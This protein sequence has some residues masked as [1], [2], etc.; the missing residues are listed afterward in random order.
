MYFSAQ[1]DLKRREITEGL[2]RVNAH[3]LGMT[4]VRGG[5]LVHY[6]PSSQ[7]IWTDEEVLEQRIVDEIR[8][9]PSHSST[10]TTR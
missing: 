6:V 8:Q 2:R 7:D 3:L 9:R 1:L 10:P 4:R 5:Y